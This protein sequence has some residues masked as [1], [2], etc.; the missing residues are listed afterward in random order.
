ML[1]D[2]ACVTFALF[3]AYINMA[4]ELA[5]KSPRKIFK[6]APSLQRFPSAFD[7]PGWS[8]DVVV[9]RSFLAQ[10]EDVWDDGAILKVRFASLVWYLIRPT[11]IAFICSGSNY[12]LLLQIEGSML[13]VR[14]RLMRSHNQR[15]ILL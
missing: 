11:S 4:A 7:H 14:V 2:R 12:L 3:V 5:H 1:R 8:P 6:L 9:L 10:A 13:Q 15:M